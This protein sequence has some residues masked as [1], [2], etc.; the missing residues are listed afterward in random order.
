M[1]SG[2]VPPPGSTCRI[3]SVIG[4]VLVGPNAAAMSR[5]CGTLVNGWRIAAARSWFT[6]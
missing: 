6:C 1:T 3:V 5:A 4:L 2:A